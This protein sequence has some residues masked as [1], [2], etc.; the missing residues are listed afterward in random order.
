MT[1]LARPREAALDLA[2]GL[3]VLGMAFMH[4]VPMDA[5]GPLLDRGLAV[6]AR[7]LEGRA[8]T[9]FCL[10]AG[11]A[12]ALQ[13]ARHGDS[14]RFPGYLRRR[15]AFLALLGAALQAGPWTTEVLLP[16][17]LMMLLAF[18]LR[19]AGPRALVAGGLLLAG[20]APWLVARGAVG[21]ETLAGA[22]GVLRFLLVDGHYP[23]V[24]WLAFPLLGMAAWDR[25]WLGPD[26]AGRTCLIS[27]GL[28]G[29]ML[30]GVALAGARHPQLALTWTP[31]SLPF[32]L[33]QASGALAGVAG[34]AW[35]HGRRGLPAWT[36][37]LADLG[38]ASLSHYLL[39]L[40]VAYL[41]LRLAHPLE[42][43]SARLGF[44]VWLGYFALAL[45]LTRRWFARR[46]RG[47]LEGLWA[48]ASGPSR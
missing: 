14:H 43:W 40:L 10:L 12:W 33:A 25:G 9:L 34:L 7:G 3:A 18:A 30:A 1:E 20:A 16:L 39:H 44:A 23:L 37:P 26:R 48:L 32:V 35:W 36:A 4:L 29:V 46:S 27:L 6:L 42:D 13:G 5:H 38:R 2:R 19:A 24:P 41:P 31:P 22:P 15:A 47:P 11:M 45:P 17:A 8:A 21:P 28:H